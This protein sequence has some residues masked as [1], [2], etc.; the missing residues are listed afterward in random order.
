MGSDAYILETKS[1]RGAGLLGW[2]QSP[3]VEVSA[4]IDEETASSDSTDLLHALNAKIDRLSSELLPEQHW[5]EWQKRYLLQ[6]LPADLLQDM[7]SEDDLLAHLAK[8]WHHT[9]ALP[10]HGVL[11]LVGPTGV[12]KTT[13]LAKLAARYLLVEHLKVGFI[14]ADT[15]RMGAVEQLKMY[16]RILEAPIEVTATPSEVAPALQKLASVDLIL[17]DTAG[18]SQFNSMQMQELRSFLQCFP[19]PSVHAVLSATTSLSTARTILNRFSKLEPKSVIYTKLDESDACGLPFLLSPE[20]P[21]CSF[22]TIG[23]R[24][25][26]D[27]MLG[28]FDNVSTWLRGGDVWTKLK[29]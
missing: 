20:A 19:N 29:A 18:R 2:L 11:V 9:D 23:Q 1:T 22:L 24:V 12:G 6:G 13:T 28:H 17:V 16:A 15:Y 14:T 3:W 8:Q 4:A 21:P 26:E 10:R 27:L 25:P 5:Q 7:A